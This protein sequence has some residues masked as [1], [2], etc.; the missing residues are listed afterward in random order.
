M[1]VSPAHAGRRGVRGYGLIKNTREISHEM[2][3]V[4][5]FLHIRSQLSHLEW[6]K[7]EP[8]PRPRTTPYSIV[9]F[10]MPLI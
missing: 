10:A 6:Q 3:G 4:V 1:R 7:P 2:N 8:P 9:A 5:R